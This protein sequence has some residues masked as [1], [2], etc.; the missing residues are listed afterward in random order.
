LAGD[1]RAEQV[2]LGITGC[3]GGGGLVSWKERWRR[4]GWPVPFGTLLQSQ[5]NNQQQ[6]LNKQKN[7]K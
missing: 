3:Q 7:L 5:Q 1:G 6:K 4:K 2:G